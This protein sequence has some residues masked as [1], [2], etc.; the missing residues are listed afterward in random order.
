MVW[1]QKMAKERKADVLS[2]AFT[3][4]GL[5]WC[6]RNGCITGPTASTVVNRRSQWVHRGMW[7]HDGVNGGLIILSATKFLLYSRVE[8]SVARQVHNLKVVGSNPTPAPILSPVRPTGKDT[9]LRTTESGFESWAGGHWG[10][11][12]AITAVRD[13]ASAHP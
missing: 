10:A 12:Y 13:R 4:K 7:C 3:T 6:I 5:A 2:I 8:Q 1:S 11:T 9:W